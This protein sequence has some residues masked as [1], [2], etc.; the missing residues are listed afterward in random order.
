MLNPQIALQKK[1]PYLKQK[2][3]DSPDESAFFKWRIRKSLQHAGFVDIS[4]IPFDF[5]HPAIP[6]SFVERAD[7]MASIIEKIPLL[8]EFAGSLYIRARKPDTETE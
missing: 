8:K 2:L 1:F 3:G 6:N 4:V 7:G 5:L